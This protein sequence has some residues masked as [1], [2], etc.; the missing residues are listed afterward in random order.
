MCFTWNTK[1]Q[2]ESQTTPKIHIPNMLSCQMNH[3][4][5]TLNVTSSI[6]SPTRLD[7]ASVPG[8][9]PQFRKQ[10]SCQNTWLNCQIFL[11]PWP[12]QVAWPS[13]L[14]VVQ[15][16]WEYCKTKNINRVNIQVSAR[17]Q[18]ALRTTTQT[19]MWAKNETGLL[20]NQLSIIFQMHNGCA[21]TKSQTIADMSLILT[22]WV[23]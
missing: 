1:H 3:W 6:Q 5:R 20:I 7:S 11:T 19:L 18:D 2:H 4:F 16:S 17:W 22:V 21:L 9:H 13:Q 15:H 23:S 8:R 12:C 14:R 10:I